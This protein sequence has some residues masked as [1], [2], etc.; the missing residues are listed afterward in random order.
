[1]LRLPTCFR[2][3]DQ[4]PDDL[5]EMVHRYVAANGRSGPV[6]VVGVRTSGSY[7]APLCAAA[8]ES[9]GITPVTVLTFRPGRRWRR[10]EAA[11]IQRV[12]AAGGRF[13]V[14]DDPPVTGSALNDAGRA[15]QELGVSQTNITFLLALAEAEPP[16]ALRLQNGVYL[17]WHEWSV[18]RRL[19]D[20]E[21]GRK[22]A[23]LLG[24]G[25]QVIAHLQQSA[26]EPSRARVRHHY[27]VEI[28]TDH[29]VTHDEL[30]V[31]GAGLGYLGRHALEVAAA[32][33]DHVPTVYGLSDGLLYLRRLPQT[34]ATTKPE[35]AETIVKYVA[36]RSAA[37]RVDSDPTAELRHRQ[38]VWETTAQ[39]LRPLFGQLGPVGQTLL[40]EPIVRDLT[41]TDNP[42]VTDGRTH[43]QHWASAVDRTFAGKN[44]FHQWSFSNR[45]LVCYDPIF[46]L[47]GAAADP[48]SSDFEQ[49]LRSIYSDRTGR[50]I[51]LERWLLYR[52]A[53]LWRLRKNGELDQNRVNEMS[54]EAMYDYLSATYGPRGAPIDLDHGALCAIDL[55]GT[56]ETALLGYPCTTPGGALTLRALAAHGYRPVL[57]TGRCLPDVIA[58]CRPFDLAGGV[59][60]Y[61][62]VVYDH[63]NGNHVDL[64]DDSARAAL[65]HVRQMLK[66]HDD[67]QIDPRYRYIVRART[68]KGPISAELAHEIQILTGGTVR[69]VTGDDQTDL[70]PISVDKGKGLRELSNVL[71]GTVAL[72]IGDTVE[73]LA[74]FAQADI[75]RA[76][77]NAGTAVRRAGIHITRGSYQRGL[78]QAC[79]DLLGHPP[80]GCPTCRQPPIARRTALFGQIL[81]LRENGVRGLATRTAHLISS[82][83][84]KRRD[85]RSS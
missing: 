61:G 19:A 68:K 48:P 54:A 45:E 74:M 38:P 6:A 62:A 43:H 33:P 58:R 11:L 49:L 55:D 27:R 79:A 17:P 56:L 8:L 69:V 23:E 70:V 20:E 50:P 37:L 26:D 59:A 53:H 44:D 67:V 73:D 63:R 3:F 40:L 4:H 71:N 42:S 35:L 41:R 64:R 81:D 24:P 46:D 39:H 16:D 2:S 5:V 32:L 83:A 10:A 9:S 65:L 72:A 84:I 34:V 15:L 60:E 31:E 14:T 66:R 21:I 47:A 85:R 51:D 7:L 77:G 82:V 29:G 52:I 75:A 57:A 30:T 22:L 1:M 13:I 80:G 25:H 28:R 36:D 12:V 18:H 76:P 78:A